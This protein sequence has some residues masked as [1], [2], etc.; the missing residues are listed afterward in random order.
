MS[1]DPSTGTTYDLAVPDGQGNPFEQRDLRLQ[2]I[3][4]RLRNAF[5]FIPSVFGLGALLLAIL[6]GRVEALH[7][8]ADD[9]GYL[10][11]LDTARLVMTT[12][13]AAMLTFMGLVFSITIVALQLA[14]AQFSPRVL[15]AF[16]RDRRTQSVLGIFLAT[17]VYALVIIAELGIAGR[18]DQPDIAPMAVSICFLLVA[19]SLA[20]FV[21]YLHHIGLS[22][23]AVGVIEAVAHE[24]RKAIEDNYPRT[25]RRLRG[26]EPPDL[27]GPVTVLRSPR[28]GAIAAGETDGLVRLAVEHDCVLRLLH[29]VG[30]FVSEGAALFESY[31]GTPPKVEHLV[32]WVD[33]DTTRTMYQDVAFGFRQLVDIAERALSPAINDPTTAVQALDRITDLLHRL[34]DRPQ[35]PGIYLDEQ[36]QVRLVRP[37]PDWD[38]FVELAFEEIRWYGANSIQV[39]RRLESAI[40][41]LL[42]IAP[43]E[44]HPPLERQRQLLE[45]S[46]RQ[47]FPADIQVR[48]RRP[49]ALGLG[50]GS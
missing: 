43:P 5:W 40:E 8:L 30:S 48:A 23:R 19:T 42:E 22:I 38:D 7:R 31:S 4:D 12:V 35:P 10:G 37:I 1:P 44:R 34:A 46:I 13:A 45:E 6:V 24:T 50:G 25:G 9:V 2:R 18:N 16:L 21:Y 26:F 39:S 41:E 11:D 36:G 28:A 15:R 47:H 33:L 29:P 49:D 17:F 32:R 14:S 20:A 27:D 3:R